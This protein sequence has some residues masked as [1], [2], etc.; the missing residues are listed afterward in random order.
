MQWNSPHKGNTL[1]VKTRFCHKWRQCFLC[2]KQ[3]W[4]GTGSDIN[5]AKVGHLELEILGSVVEVW[6]FEFNLL[7]DVQRAKYV[8]CFP[9]KH[10]CLIT[11]SISWSW[12]SCLRLSF[13]KSFFFLLHVLLPWGLHFHST[14]GRC[15]QLKCQNRSHHAAK[16]WLDFRFWKMWTGWELCCQDP[17]Y[18]TSFLFC[19][20]FFE[21]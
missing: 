18:R 10:E 11:L 3:H 2:F 9:F 13:C 7:I 12:R 5:K 15:S 21:R 8:L 6:Q 1:W 16:V 4:R 17:L 19:F 20:F 14:C